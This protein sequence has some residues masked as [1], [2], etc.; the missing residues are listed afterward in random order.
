MLTVVLHCCADIE[1][2][3]SKTGNFKKFPVFV[4]M[5]LSAVTQVGWGAAT[6]GGGG[7]AVVGGDASGL[8]GGDA[9][10]GGE[11]CQRRR[12]PRVAWDAGFH[13]VAQVAWTA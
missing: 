1:D 11:R 10:H 8:G 3:T 2:I 7:S 12:S 9:G 4:K 13:R 5:L 6:Q